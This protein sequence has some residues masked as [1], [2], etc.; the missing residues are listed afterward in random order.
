MTF[1]VQLMK[2]LGVKVEHKAF[3]KD[4]TVNS[5]KE[6]GCDAVFLG[7]LSQWKR[8]CNKHVGHLR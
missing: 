3:G 5:L 8:H 4:M 2:D 1:E 7:M 6:Q